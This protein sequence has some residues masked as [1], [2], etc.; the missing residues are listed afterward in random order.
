[1]HFFHVPALEYRAII[2]LPL[3]WRGTKERTTFCPCGC[4]RAEK[5]RAESFIGA[6][7]ATAG[8]I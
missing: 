1:M 4:V 2:G 7:Q 5:H 6:G 8:V 3:P